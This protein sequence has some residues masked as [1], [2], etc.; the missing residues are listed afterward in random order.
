MYIYLT[1]PYMNDLNDNTAEL[2]ETIRSNCG[3]KGVE[4]HQRLQNRK[5]KINSCNPAVFL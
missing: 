3:V 4:W 1:T 5:N 2:R